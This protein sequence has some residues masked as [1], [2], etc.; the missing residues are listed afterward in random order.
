LPAQSVK[1]IPIVSGS[2][3]V[4]KNELDD[5][6]DLLEDIGPKKK[7]APGKAPVNRA[8]DDDFNFEGGEDEDY[9]WGGMNGGGNQAK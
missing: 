9:L 8:N 3:A 4:N 2:K 6:E 7:P 1:P 5:L